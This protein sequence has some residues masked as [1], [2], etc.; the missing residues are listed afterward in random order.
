MSEE[1]VAR[2]TDK[3]LIAGIITSEAFQKCRFIVQKLYSSFPNLYDEPGMRPMLNLEWEDYLIKARDDDAL[4]KHLT[5]KFRFSLN[6]DWYEI[7]KCHLTEHLGNIMRKYRQLAYLTISINS[8]IVGTMLFELYNDLVPLACENFLSKCKLTVGGYVGTPIH[9]QLIQGAEVLKKIENVPTY[10]QAPKQH[11]DICKAG[12]LIFNPPPDY[13]T[14]EE[15]DKFQ[16]IGPTTL[17]DALIGPPPVDSTFS[18][19]KFQK[20]LYGLATDMKSYFP[21]WRWP[22]LMPEGY[23]PKDS[24]SVYDNMARPFFDLDLIDNWKMLLTPGSSDITI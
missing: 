20:G 15:L 2:A 3:F 11:I 19:S 16:R 17:L 12:E 24:D 4:T 5:K 10:Y 7:G 22:Y 13:M 1:S 18:F 23:T 8:R 9:S 6:K 21:A 14:D